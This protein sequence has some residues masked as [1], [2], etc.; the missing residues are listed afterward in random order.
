MN[1]LV[2]VFAVLSVA[3]AISTLKWRANAELFETRWKESDRKRANLEMRIVDTE[4]ENRLAA[5]LMR[6]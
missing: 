1:I 3:L 5:K 4:K 2:I 6:V